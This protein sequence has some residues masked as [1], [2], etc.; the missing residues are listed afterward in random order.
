MTCSSPR[1]AG[2]LLLY[3]TGACGLCERA[4][5]LVAPWRERGW[6]VEEVDIASDEALLRRYG[7]RIPVL[8]RL[9][10]GRELHWPFAAGQLRTFLG[11]RR[12][13]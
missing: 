8:R 13:V 3:G 12:S 4:L 2:R 5:A 10:S 7:L 6:R 11:E 9:D 1:R